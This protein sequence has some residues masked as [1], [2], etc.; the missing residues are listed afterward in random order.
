M[1]FADTLRDYH[2]LEPHPVA[3]GVY[4]TK[5]GVRGY[6]EI[7][8]GAALLAQKSGPLGGRVYGRYIQRGFRGFG[9]GA[10]RG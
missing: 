1:T 6:P 3:N 9:C 10:A 8:P 5:R 2:Q 4:V 7:H